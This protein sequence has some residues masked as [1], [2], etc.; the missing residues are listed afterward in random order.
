MGLN[1]IPGGECDLDSD[2]RLRLG[3]GAGWVSGSGSDLAVIVGLDF[4]PPIMPSFPA[5]F[6][7]GCC[8]RDGG[9]GGT[10]FDGP[11][12]GEGEAGG[13][14]VGSLGGFFLPPITPSPP[15]GFFCSGS[16]SLDLEG[17]GWG[18]GVG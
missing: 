5:R 3:L 10:G 11:G 15:R 12:D 13:G 17:D 9:G 7:L 1:P 16:L 2:L 8:D 4:L 6:G 18:D 14:G